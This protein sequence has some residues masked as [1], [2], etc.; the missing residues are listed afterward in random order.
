MF[1]INII[2]AYSNLHSALQ[3]EAWRDY[4]EVKAKRGGQLSGKYFIN[5][6]KKEKIS[7]IKYLTHK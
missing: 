2:F 5:T 4:S 1:N 3:F 7:K 6:M